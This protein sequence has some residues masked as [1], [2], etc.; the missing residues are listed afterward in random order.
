MKL[1]YFFKF[2]K[3]YL[4]K[5]NSNHEVTENPKI[6]FNTYFD[7]QK[8]TVFG[9]KLGDKA[10]LIPKNVIEKIRPSSYTFD[11]KHQDNKVFKIIDGIRSEISEDEFYD[12]T[13]ET[14]GYMS[15]KGNLGITVKDGLVHNVSFY[16]IFPLLGITNRNDIIEEFGEAD[17]IERS[18]FGRTFYYFDKNLQI[19]WNGKE[20]K[21]YEKHSRIVVGNLEKKPTLYKANDILYQYLRIAN[22]DKEL[23]NNP[24]QVDKNNQAEYFYRLNNLIALLKAFG[25]VATKNEFTEE[26]RKRST[27]IDLGDK[28]Q[29]PLAQQT[30]IDTYVGSPIMYFQKGYFIQHRPVAIYTNII[31]QLQIYHQ[32]EVERFENTDSEKLKQHYQMLKDSKGSIYDVNTLF[33]WLLAYRIEAQKSLSSLGGLVSASSA[34]A[35]LACDLIHQANGVFYEELKKVDVLICNIID[36]EERQITQKELVTKF[37]FL[38]VDLDAIDACFHWSEEFTPCLVD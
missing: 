14:D 31:A 19:Y 32:R 26:N 1:R 20:T 11:T 23:L 33:D 34:G 22:W 18:S 7:L 38:E 21:N 4:D 10:A 6:L 35:K 27:I 28:S 3:K 5:M 36:P 8:L 37:G 16:D 2:A 12:L 29:E 25:L 13:I 9:V 17:E 15:C 30:Y 24:Q